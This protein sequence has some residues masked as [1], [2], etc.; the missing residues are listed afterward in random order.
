MTILGNHKDRQ[1]CQQEK[2]NSERATTINQRGLTPNQLNF[3]RVETAQVTSLSFNNFNPLKL[4]MVGTFSEQLLSNLT[5]IVS[6]W[7]AKKSHFIDIIDRKFYVY[8]LT[9]MDT[10]TISNS[11]IK[12]A[13][14][15]ILLINPFMALFCDRNPQVN[16]ENMLL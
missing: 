13:K 9:I 15:C 4:P 16:F 2:E 6:F 8:E 10:G 3:V 5:N 1:S 14:V 11:V 7:Y 12:A